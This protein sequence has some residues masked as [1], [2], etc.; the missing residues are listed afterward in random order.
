MLTLVTGRARSGKTSYLF[1]EI[2]R[3]MDAGESGMLLIVPEQYSHDAER[4]LCAECGDMLSLHVETLSFSRLCGRVF[5][6]TGG[7]P[8]HILDEGGQILVIHRAVET[9]APDL[10]VF[11]A[12]RMRAELPERLLSAI[13]EFKTMNITPEALGLMAERVAKP[14]ADKLRDL[15]LI[16]SAYNAILSTYGADREDRLTRLADVIFDSTAGDTGHIFFDGFSDFTAQESRVVE[17]LMRKGAQITVCLT[18]APG[19]D[20]EA[21]AIP[22]R[23]EEQLR[24]LAAAYGVVTE[25]IVVE[26]PAGTVADEL[27]FLEENLFGYAPAVFSGKC[28]AITVNSARSRYEECEFAASKVWELVRAGYR[29]RDIGVMARDWEGYGRLCE[30]VFENYGV[31][32]FSGGRTDISD[33]PPAA[34]IDAALDIAVSGWEYRSVFRYLKTGL[35]Y[36]EADDCALLENYAIRWNIRG[37]MWLRDWTLPPSGSGAE[38]GAEALRKLN[39]LR[40]MITKPITALSD[41]IRRAGSVEGKIRALYD[42][43][44]ETE[45]PDR[46]MAKMQL[47]EKRGEKR[48][49]GEYSQIWDI[50]VNAM[51]QMS[52]IPGDSEIG[53]VEFRKLFSLILSRYDVGVIPVSLDRT[54]LGGIAMSRRRDLKCLI[55]LGA[56]DESMPMLAGGGGILSDSEREELLRIGAGMPGGL[57]ER[58]YREMNMLYSTFTLPSRELI[59]SYPGAGGAR[60]SFIIKRINEMFGTAET[61]TDRD[62]YMT[63]AESPCYELATMAGE[64]GGSR[65]AAAAR[66]YFSEGGGDAAKRLAEAG[67]ILNAGR[68]NLSSAA[69]ERLYG[70]KPALSAS[71]VEKYYSCPYSY[72]LHNGLRLNKRR[73]AGFDAPEAGVFMHYVL[74]GVSREIMETTGFKNA[75]KELCDE[76]ITR[77]SGRYVSEALHDFEGAGARYIYLF[78]RLAED[79]RFVVADMLD[80]LKDSDFEPLDFELRFDD[81]FDKP[82]SNADAF[83]MS[84]VVDRV[85]GYVSDGKTYLRVIDYKTGN[86]KFSLADVLHGRKMQ[87]LIYLFALQKTGEARYG[88]EIIPAGVLYVPARDRILRAPRNITGDKLRKKREDDLRRTGLILSDPAI[89][90]AMESGDVKRFLPVRQAKDGSPAGDSLVS[91]GQLDLLSEH[92]GDMLA[93]AA[94]G[95]AGGEIRCSPYYKSE[96]DNACRDCEYGT[97]C[98]FDEAVGD[99]RRFMRKMD[100]GETWELLRNARFDSATRS[101]SETRF[102][103]AGGEVR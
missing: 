66:E 13:K 71:R 83:N 68:G 73:A 46:L 92:I 4:Q 17:E 27:A 34:L 75:D 90:K 23:T 94:D 35:A 54:A 42:F 8:Q 98:G 67:A 99:K 12:D 63:S 47:L 40:G 93:R 39:E 5:S 91:S 36:P 3:R 57:E 24:R 78:K 80:E 102:Y 74:E 64:K 32:Y 7:E 79:A 60:P 31:P 9:S 6:E 45:L 30:S 28:G 69:A 38:D 44:E 14:L 18:L 21:F 95:V 101:D 41:G 86:T 15:S 11:G 50:I 37:T 82:G 76:L 97:V 77:Y 2:R 22:R 62:E 49:A 59:I 61:E 65:K 89:I 48:L 43:L 85:D 87:M 81:A 52:G 19:D 1:R 100:V 70:R 103:S 10:K 84:G 55:I 20:G 29:W 58:L 96:R 25:A 53:G 51:E 16:F 26:R 33:S 56:T 72:F 88:G